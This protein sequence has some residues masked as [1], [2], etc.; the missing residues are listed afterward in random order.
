MKLQFRDIEP[1]VKNPNK[2]A[3]VILIYGPDHGLVKE[4]GAI[5]GKTIVQDLSDPFNVAVIEASALLEDPAKL[6]DE[7]NAMSMMGG[8]R[9][10]RVEGASDKITKTLQGY[11]ADPS[12]DN[13]VL[14]L[15]AELGPRSP[16]RVLCEKDKAAA[17][18][19]CYVED[20]RD[21]TRFIR[22]TLAAEKLNADPDTI[23]WLS[24]N[25]SGDRLK[26]RSELDKLITYIGP[27]KGAVHLSDAVEACASAGAQN[28]DNLV[29]GVAGGNSD[30]ALKTFATLMEEGIPFITVLRVL[31]NHFRRLHM[32]KA[33][34]ANGADMDMAL[35]KL[36]PPVFFKQAPAFKK[37]LNNWSLQGLDKVMERLTDLEMQC[38]RTGMPSVTLCAQAILSMSRMRAA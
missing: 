6:S 11:L 37:Q 32:T 5:I 34:M 7:A 30:A 21:L 26:V 9:L 20:A 25:I 35:K 2:A 38:K 29:Y 8:N 18:L 3:R 24:E 13:L 16:L 31:Q 23:T 27:E 4:R 22:E 19:P 12:P 10:V 1:F 33:H 17:A 28:F 15:A 36:S 14:V